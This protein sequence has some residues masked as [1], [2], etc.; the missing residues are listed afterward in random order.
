MFEPHGLAIR[1][2]Q[3]IV[4][5]NSAE[6]AHN[7]D[8]GGI[9]QQGANQLVP[10]GGKYEIKMKASEYQVTIKCGIHPWMKAW[11]RVF[12]H[13]Y[14]AVTDEDGKFEI[15]TAPAGDWRIV[16][17]HDEAGWRN[18]ETRKMGDPIKVKVK[19]VTDLG[20]LKIE[21]RKG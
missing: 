18:Q 5:K 14:F 10:P 9:R 6:F 16:I 20:D 2:G 17:W 7:V 11:V 19:D 3:I 8:W 13:P 12:D 15:K 1:E 21:P 4:A